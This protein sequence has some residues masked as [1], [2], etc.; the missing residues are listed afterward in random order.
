Y[1][2]QKWGLNA[3]LIGDAY[4]NFELTGVVVVMLVFG[5]LL[6][7]LYLGFRQGKLHCAIYAVAVMSC[8][9]IFWVSIEVWPQAFVTLSATGLL[10][11]LGRTVLRVRYAPEEN[12]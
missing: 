10:I 3:S 6:K 8:V 5:A 11:Y 1:N 9:Q 7:L 2:G 4:L 12:R